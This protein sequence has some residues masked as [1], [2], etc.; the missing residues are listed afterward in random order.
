MSL[1]SEVLRR[2]LTGVMV[3]EEE[4]VV[5]QGRRNLR[6]VLVMVFLILGL[7]GGEDRGERERR[8]REGVFFWGVGLVF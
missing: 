2:F 3:V 7:S 5:K 8:E 1:R 6:R 4:E